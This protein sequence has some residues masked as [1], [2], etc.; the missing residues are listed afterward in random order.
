MISRRNVLLTG[1]AAGATGWPFARTALAA[2]QW[3]PLRVGETIDINGVRYEAECG[4]NGVA[5]EYSKSQIVRCTMIAGNAWSE[6]DPKNAERAELD[7]YKRRIPAGQ[8]IWASWS[9]LYEH[10]PWSTSDWCIL[11][12]IYPWSGLVLKPGG[13]LH[14]AGAATD[15]P[16]DVWPTRF[17]T[18]IPQGTWLHFVER[19]VLDPGGK[20]GQWQS[21][22]NGKKVLDLAA[23]VGYAKAA[24]GY[25]FKFGIYR[26]TQRRDG[27]KVDETV[28][29]RYANVRFGTED[30]T[31]IIATPDRITEA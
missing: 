26:G 31:R 10:G 19:V 27:T 11:R 1:A 2:D 23:P 15:D 7:G 3:I 9:M 22:L 13:I 14:W 4:R 17:Q 30:L 5:I 25:W 20:N 21:W 16:K 12:Q 18:A 29:V 28:V 8:V 6:D 24:N